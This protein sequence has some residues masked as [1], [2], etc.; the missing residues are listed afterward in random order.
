MVNNVAVYNLSDV[1]IIYSYILL[2]WLVK[3]DYC[4]YKH[5]KVCILG[6]E[7]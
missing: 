4:M 3:K 5:E 1:Q 7:Y 2:M 6:F